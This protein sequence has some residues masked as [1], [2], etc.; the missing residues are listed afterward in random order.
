ME[1]DVILP[2]TEEATVESDV[3]SDLRLIL[4]NRQALPERIEFTDGPFEVSQLDYSNSEMK[5]K[6]HQLRT[7]VFADEL[8][9]VTP[10]Q[11]MKS[12]DYD[13]TA[14]HIGL[15]HKDRLGE[16]AGYV[17]LITPTA[18]GKGF[19]LDGPFKEMVP[20]EAECEWHDDPNNSFE[21]TRIAVEKDLR[22]SSEGNKAAMC[23][24][25]AAYHFSIATGRDE[26]YIVTTRGLLKL[27]QRYGFPF[28]QIGVEHKF[29]AKDKINV[30]STMSSEEAK[31]NMTDKNPK[32]LAWFLE[33]CPQP[34]LKSSEK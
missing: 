14:I 3:S 5:R 10:E 23:L 31:T 13:E 11:E 12:D 26:W 24:Y 8:G 29:H 25:K 28:K 22:Q 9:W 17:R 32:L 27:L 33:G 30:A 19:M 21:V 20:N 1:T 7:A 34:P 6:I 4:E 18:N 16:L 2:E 15:F